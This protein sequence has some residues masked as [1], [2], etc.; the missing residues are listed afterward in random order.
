VGVDVLAGPAVGYPA[1]EQDPPFGTGEDHGESRFTGP[2]NL[3]G[4]PALS[5]P[6]P[7]PGL[8]AGLQL[9]GRR[10]GD[11]ALL[12]IATAAESLLWPAGPGP[13]ATPYRQDPARR[14]EN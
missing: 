12:R 5:L 6:V 10:G 9:A 4:H 14:G 8:P 11:W 1:P 3:S 2:Y 7:A 13:A